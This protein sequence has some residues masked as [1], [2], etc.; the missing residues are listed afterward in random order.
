MESQKKS[1]IY[2]LFSNRYINHTLFILAGVVLGW[3]LFRDRGGHAQET[4]PSSEIMQE[5]IWT[6]S[7][8]PHI[9]ATEPGDC[10]ICGMDL[11][12]LAQNGSSGIDPDAVKLTKEAAAL[13]D[14]HTTITS[15]QKP[16]KEV[17]LYGKITADERMLQSQVSH[18]SGRIEKLFVT[19]TG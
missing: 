8:H 9:R 3:L 12:P 2:R 15:R 1:L 13:A 11:I 5:T 16:V 4:G 7:M 19:F 6:C 10:P 18:V 17:R 14:V